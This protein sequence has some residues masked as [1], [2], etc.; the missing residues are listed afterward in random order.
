MVLLRR[1]SRT[2]HLEVTSHEQRVKVVGSE[3]KQSIAVRLSVVRKIIPV[4]SIVTDGKNMV[5]VRI[6][7]G[8]E[9]VHHVVV[10]EMHDMVRWSHEIGCHGN[11]GSRRSLVSWAREAP[12][13]VDRLNLSKQSVLRRK[14]IVISVNCGIS[15]LNVRVV[16]TVELYVL[17]IH[18]VALSGRLVP[19]NS[20]TSDE[21]ATHVGICD[22]EIWTESHFVN[23]DLAANERLA[24]QDEA[25]INRHDD[26][27]SEL[28]RNL[29]YDGIV[30][31]LVS[32]RVDTEN[33]SCTAVD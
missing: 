33:N 18:R 3:S 21:L 24:E 30:A 26:L 4:R 1:S 13:R 14:H 19:H 32:L 9:R 22:A 16:P 23:R 17:R 28:L 10:G 20:E 6:I 27:L 15:A 25:E 8:S 29:A 12:T 5:K 2:S 7:H 31:L 11:T